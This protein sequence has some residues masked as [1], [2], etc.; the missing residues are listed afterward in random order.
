MLTK[1]KTHSARGEDYAERFSHEM[2]EFLWV[3]F[4][5]AFGA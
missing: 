3:R 5:R 2:A 4:Y 1:R